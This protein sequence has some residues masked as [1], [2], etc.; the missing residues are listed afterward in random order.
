M[1]FD[2][3]PKTMKKLSKA[4]ALNETVIRHTI[5]NAGSSLTD[6]SSY[7]PPE[8]VKSLVENL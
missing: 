8:S 2:S 5:L 1:K 3:S 7:V 6:V 4:L